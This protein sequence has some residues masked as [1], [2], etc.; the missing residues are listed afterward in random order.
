MEDIQK[1]ENVGETECDKK[2]SNNATVRISTS[3]GLLHLCPKHRRQLE[4]KIKNRIEEKY[5]GMSEEEIAE[6]LMQ[7]DS[8][9]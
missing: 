4:E 7:G 2:C 8:I 1:I 6:K 5:E 3:N 9:L